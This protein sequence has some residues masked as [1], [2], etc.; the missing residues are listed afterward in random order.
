MGILRTE[1]ILGYF[2]VG[3]S[4]E[5]CLQ[6]I[7]YWL[8]KG[9][10]KKFIACANPH[11]L[12]IAK[13]DEV[14]K[15]ALSSADLLTPDGAGIVFA[16]KMF[17]GFIRKRITGTD[18]FVGV[19]GLLNKSGG[20]AF[21]LG[22]TEK[23]LHAIRAKIGKEFPKIKI[24]GTYSP[25]FRTA[26]SENENTKMIMA[27]NKAQPDVLWVG[28]TAPKQE[29]WIHQN[30]K[31]LNVGFVGAIGAVFDF[32]SGN[33][34]RSHPV[35]QRLGLEW[36]PRFLREPRRLW[37]RNIKSTPIFLWLIIKEKVRLFNLSNDRH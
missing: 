7:N 14:F 33:V 5:I 22:T 23:T 9:E 37:E 18:I 27:I 20:S 10:R 28:M 13:R 12:V 30:I 3:N 11:S 15:K 6:Q 36:L 31:Q 16:S 17:N 8:K 4:I 32:Y 25:P 29:K 2:V 19:C 26:F 34:K 21:F 24:V 1:K 35:F